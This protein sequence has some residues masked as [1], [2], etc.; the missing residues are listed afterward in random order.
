MSMQN[1]TKHTRTEEVVATF[2]QGIAE[3]NAKST[4]DEEE[5][6]RGGGEDDKNNNTDKQEEALISVK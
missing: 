3:Q 5:V 1:L 4:D 2:R 6:L